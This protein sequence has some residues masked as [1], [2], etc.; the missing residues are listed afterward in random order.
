MMSIDP[1][2]PT[3]PTEQIRLLLTA[4]IQGGELE[5]KL[6]TARQLAGDLRVAAEN[7]RQGL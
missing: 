1:L 7:R 6:P 3:C 2:D 4:L 5:A